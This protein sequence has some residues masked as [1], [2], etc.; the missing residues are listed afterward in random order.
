L[1]LIEI[2]VPCIGGPLIVALLIYIIIKVKKN[3]D[4]GKIKTDIL[5]DPNIPH[6]KTDTG[7]KAQNLKPKDTKELDEAGGDDEE[8]DDNDSEKNN[9]SRKKSEI[10]S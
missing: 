5:D 2:I 1:L 3:R 7:K 8:D 10:M 6:V 4:H 9:Q